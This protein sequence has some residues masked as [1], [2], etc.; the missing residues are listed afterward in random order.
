MHTRRTI[1]RFAVSVP[2][3][4]RT[5]CSGQALSRTLSELL[6][7]NP[8]RSCIGISKFISPQIS[9]TGALKILLVT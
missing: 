3:T 6:D 9:R 8:G 5:S 4:T 1:L 7:C 2:N